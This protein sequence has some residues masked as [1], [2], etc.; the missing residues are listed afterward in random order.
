MEHRHTLSILVENKFGVLARVAGLFSGRGFNIDSLN[1]A[2]TNKKNTSR[3][4]VVVKGDDRVLEQVTKQLNKLVNVIDVDDFRVGEFVD[5]EL[6]LVKIRTN[7]KT[8]AEAM[9]VVD[10]F[11]AKIVDVQEESLLIEATGNHSK[12][13]AFLELM[14]HF[15]IIDLTRTGRVAIKR[16]HD[17]EEE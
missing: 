9:Q 8:R 6:V 10:I 2:P 14:D 16:K 15:G 4:T 13:S 5:R 17:S 12:V 1:V 11:R 7:E 3:M